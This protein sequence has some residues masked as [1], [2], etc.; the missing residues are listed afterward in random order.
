LAKTGSGA[1]PGTGTNHIGFDA[2]CAFASSTKLNIES[3]D[4]EMLSSGHYEDRVSGKRF[5]RALLPSD[6]LR[7]NVLRILI[8]HIIGNE[9]DAFID[10]CKERFEDT[11]L[12]H[13]Y[14]WPFTSPFGKSTGENLQS[15]CVII[16]GLIMHEILPTLID[17]EPI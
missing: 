17:I 9:S 4:T 10:D 8:P 3:S 7:D 15:L 14:F 2:F 11:C 5:G 16:L 6:I 13:G 12:G 1:K